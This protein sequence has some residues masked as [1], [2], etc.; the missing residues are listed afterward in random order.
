M[1]KKAEGSMSIVL[2]IREEILGPKHPKVA[3]SLNDVAEL[4]HKVQRNKEAERLYQRALQ[5][6]EEVFGPD[7]PFTKSI[8]DNLTQLRS[9]N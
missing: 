6:R 8:R 5:I 2:E 9:E 3:S 1:Y 7:H 4:C